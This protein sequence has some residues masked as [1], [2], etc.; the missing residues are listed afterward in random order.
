MWWA[1]FELAAPELAA[2]G[3]EMLDRGGVLLVGTTRRDGSPRI[4]PC[5][6]LFLDGHLYLGMMWQSKKALDLLRD[7]RCVVHSIV[8]ARDGTE[9]EF[10]V[11]G[12]A[13]D[14]RH[15]DE[16]TRFADGLQAKIDW[17]P[18]DPYHLFDTDIG[19]VAFVRYSEEGGQEVER[20][21][22]AG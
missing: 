17:R 13:V 10:K 5:E 9:G 3:R 14:V 6:P 1:E 16:R 4:S 8:T 15:P 12:R 22:S 19:S 7:P 2:R 18:E 11:Y 21:N 20:W